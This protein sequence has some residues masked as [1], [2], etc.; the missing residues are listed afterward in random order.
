MIK[1]KLDFSYKYD[2]DFAERYHQ[3]REESL[4]RRIASQL[5][6]RMAR[7]SLQLAGSPKSVLDLPC[8]TG[9]FWSMLAEEPDRVLLAGD[10]SQAMIQTA[11][12]HHPDIAPR[13]QLYHLDALAIDLPDRSVETVFCMRLLHHIFET[14]ARLQIYREFARVSRHTA[15]ISV[16]VT[17]NF[18]AWRRQYRLRHRH[19]PGRNRNVLDPRQAEAEFNMAGW[20]VIGKVDLLPYHSM[21]RTYVLALKTPTPS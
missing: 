20:K 19:Q 10:S 15:C 9:R 5:E 18:H 11:I 16:R 12:H 8:G 6:I 2:Q 7:R 14:E 17:G 21:W 4:E 3:S 1:S 13:F